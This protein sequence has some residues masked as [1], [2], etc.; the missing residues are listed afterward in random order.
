MLECQA[1]V[2]G[3]HSRSIVDERRFTRSKRN[4][5]GKVHE[6]NLKM[7]RNNQQQQLSSEC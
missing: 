5:N 7:L 2:P 6:A 1:Q 4:H 3:L